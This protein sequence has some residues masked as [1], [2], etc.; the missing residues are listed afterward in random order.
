ML[1]RVKIKGLPKAKNGGVSYNQLAPMYMPN[2]MG[3]KPIQVRDTLQPVPRELAN[4][5]AEKDETALIT[6]ANGLPAHYKIGGKRHSQGGTPLN[7]PDDTFIFSDTRSMLIKDPEVLK[8][9][10][11]TKSKT[12]A[13]I[14]KKYDINKYREIL[15][16]PDMDK[17][18]KE[19]AEKMIANY[20]LKLA[21]LALYQEST[22][23]FPAGI[24]TVAL[25]YFAVNNIDP[26]DALPLKG[27]ETPQEE[28]DED[29]MYSEENPSEEEFVDEETMPE[30]QYGMNFR[31][32]NRLERRIN[33]LRQ[34]QQFDPTTGIYMQ[35]G[36]NG[37]VIYLDGNGTPLPPNVQ[38]PKELGF[39]APGTKVTKTTKTGTQTKTIKVDR[40][41]PEGAT[42]VKRSDYKTDEEYRKA[43][44]KAFKDA[45]NKGNVYT[46]DANGKSFKVVNKAFQVPEYKGKDADKAFKGNKDVAGRY[47]YIEDQLMSNSGLQQ[48]L[49]DATI[50]E[51]KDPNSQRAK[52]L[53]ARGVDVNKM[54]DGLT[55]ETVS[56]Q[57]LDM[58]KRNIALG[59]HH[60]NVA[61]TKNAPKSGK[62]V[63]NE[64]LE[65][66]ATAA[67]VSM[68]NAADAALQQ[69]AY[70]AMNNLAEAGEA[71]G[72]IPG[73]VGAADEPG[74]NKKISPIDG[75]YT[76][77]TAGEIIG[78]PGEAV[79]EEDLGQDEIAEEIPG[80][81][82]TVEEQQNPNAD[83]WLQDIVATT[84][85]LGDLARVKKYTP[86]SPK[87]APYVPTPTFYD[88]T[89]EL[90]AISEQAN[91]ATQGAGAYA[92]AQAYNARASQIQGNAAKAAADTLGRYNN[93]NV[94]AAN[95]FELT[96]ANVFNQTAMANADIAKNLYD[97]NIIANQQ[98]DNAK[99]QARQQLRQSYINAL[100][101]RAKAQTMNAVYGD[102]YMV[103]TLSGGYTTFT[104]GDEMVADQSA[105]YDP[106]ISRFEELRARMPQDVDS[107]TVWEMATQTPGKSSKRNNTAADAYM[108]A[109]GY[110]VG[111]NYS[112]I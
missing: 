47:Q 3:Q 35:T 63:S 38:L 19:T 55:P 32:G 103:D 9:F 64:E 51:L 40:K 28:M 79:G 96:K 72:F 23:G 87:L 31:R 34:R 109:Y 60:G 26:Q 80:E 25:P 76:N 95:Q 66:A 50:K 105:G 84:G 91:L 24:P 11:E 12:P 20:N 30:A 107:Q 37:E 93:L 27:Q 82:L 100:T 49:Y 106:Y 65:N 5:E 104:G 69:A 17:R 48:K 10:D 94:G 52:A 43:R 6:D 1:K 86:W 33:R 99:A 7:L 8:E 75:I 73:Q 36:R 53:E 67:G 81:E 61:K 88:P 29:E 112:Q 71:E 111:P 70:R 57:F 21:K 89:R 83:F 16:D 110:N 42:V 46:T 108:Q 18:S 85:A 22:K 78:V 59:V 98:Y 39:M 97:S 101:N 92:P 14:A 15:A 44:D 2:N 62:D 4:L 68:P 74:K 41:I 56:K 58:Q 102:N 13:Q 45:K 77:T 54:I 90:A